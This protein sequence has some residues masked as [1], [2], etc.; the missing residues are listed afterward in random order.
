MLFGIPIVSIWYWCVDQEMAQRV[1]SAKNLGEAQLGT[2]FAGLFK[3]IPVFVTGN[4]YHSFHLFLVFILNSH[5]K[6]RSR[7]AH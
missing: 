4:N 2:S 1:M 5:Q 6:A 7:V 3:T